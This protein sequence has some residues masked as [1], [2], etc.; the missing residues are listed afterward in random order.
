MST[1]DAFERYGMALSHSEIVAWDL[2]VSRASI[3]LYDA[4]FETACSYKP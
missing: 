4:S 1:S 2:V 3:D